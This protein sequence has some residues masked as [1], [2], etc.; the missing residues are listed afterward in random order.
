MKFSMWIV[1]DWLEAFEPKPRITRGEMRIKGVR[2]FAEGIEP[3]E[4]LLY[5]GH[6]DDFIQSGERG[7][8]CANGED[9]ILLNT[10]D[11]FRVM[12]KD[13]PGLTASQF[14][15]N[16]GTYTIKA[17]AYD[18]NDQIIEY[19]QIKREKQVEERVG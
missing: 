14:Y 19:C 7:V 8:I 9:L 11:E 6:A 16:S 3:E 18:E 1:N 13:G 15:E 4:D 12:E 2:Y 5:V 17:I 10:E